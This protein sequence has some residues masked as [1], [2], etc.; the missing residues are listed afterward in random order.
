MEAKSFKLIFILLGLGAVMYLVSGDNSSRDITLAPN[1]SPARKRSRKAKKKKK[2]PP[3]RVKKALKLV[4]VYRNVNTGT[5]S[6]QEK[7]E[8][9]WRIT[10]HPNKVRLRNARF[11]V[12]Q[13]GRK[14]VL[15][16]RRKNV[17]AYIEGELV[18]TKSTI[19]GK[20]LTYDPYKTSQFI[21][22]D[23]KKVL[24]ADEVSVDSFGIIKAKGIA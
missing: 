11:R 9:G 20:L 23:G 10:S 6:A 3:S 22:T 13:G 24:H 7:T 2:S 19:S 17:H 21:T 14:K 12:N 18:D 15:E 1:P 4:R 16:D 5:F 8:K